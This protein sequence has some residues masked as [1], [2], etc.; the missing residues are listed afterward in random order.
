MNRK[1]AGVKKK[2]GYIERF[3]KSFKHARLVFEFPN[4]HLREYSLG[5]TEET[6]TIKIVFK[7]ICLNP[8]LLDDKI[9]YK[10]PGGMEVIDITEPLRRSIES[11]D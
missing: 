9:N 11:G 7:K 1:F 10:P 8:E 3:K 5:S 2:L 6:E 4:N